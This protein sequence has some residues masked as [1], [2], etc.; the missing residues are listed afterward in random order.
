MILKVDHTVALD[1]PKQQLI[2]RYKQRILGPLISGISIIFKVQFVINFLKG[3]ST[4][5]TVIVFDNL[6]V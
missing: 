4:N 5:H 2:V 3:L 6:V 1:N